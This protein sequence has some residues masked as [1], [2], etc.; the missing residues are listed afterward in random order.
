MNNKQAKKESQPYFSAATT[1]LAPTMATK[2]KLA[3]SDAQQFEVDEKVAFMSDT[4][5]NMIEDTGAEE[6]VPLPNVTGKILSRV[7]EYCRFHVE[8]AEKGADQKPAKSEDEVK[9]R[10]CA[11]CVR[12]CVGWVPLRVVLV[13]AC[14]PVLLR[15]LRVRGHACTHA[16][17]HARS[18]PCAAPRPR[19]PAWGGLCACPLP[20]P[21]QARAIR[22]PSGPGRA[23]ALFAFSPAAPSL[24]ARTPPTA[25]TPSPTLPPAHHPPPPVRQAWDAEFV[26]VDQSTLFDLILAANYL[27]IKSLLDLTCQ[28]VAQM[29]KGKSPEVGRGG[30]GARRR[31]MRRREL[32]SVCARPRGEG[33]ARAWPGA[34]AA[35]AL[36]HAHTPSRPLLPVRAVGVWACA[37][38]PALPPNAP[39]T[40][41]RTHTISCMWAVYVCRV[42]RVRRMGGRR[43][44]PHHL[45]PCVSSLR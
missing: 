41:A 30:G 8:A 9:V 3:S 16:H 36:A 24:P 42:C 17:P 10:V 38:G 29:I 45:A 4:V 26:K 18:C 13:H 32:R 21:A 22:A 12:A 7:I 14:V 44:R 39:C 5:K 43:G 40:R 19:A 31:G 35:H 23:R 25:P 27:N 15:A 1:P 28:T 34:V 37:I 20:H 6:V 11:A 2:V 33:R